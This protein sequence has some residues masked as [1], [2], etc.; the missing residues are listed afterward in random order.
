M[1][2]P[3]KRRWTVDAPKKVGPTVSGTCLQASTRRP[4]GVQK[5]AKVDA[6]WT[7]QI[8]Q[9]GPT[10]SG[11]ETAGF[12][13]CKFDR[14]IKRNGGFTSGTKTGTCAGVHSA[15]TKAAKVDAEWT[16][17]I[18]QVGPT[19]SGFET[20]GYTKCKFDRF[21]KQNGRI[22]LRYKNRHVCR[23]P[24]GVHKSNASG[25]LVDTGSKRAAPR[26]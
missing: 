15:S 12:T 20:A 8:R 2:P 16:P 10:V 5:A 22:Y 23:R 26:R 4:L 7:P 24:L 18:R 11:F 9:V 17:Q 14:F 1:L 3:Q 21:R 25:L 13:K 19:V 6:E